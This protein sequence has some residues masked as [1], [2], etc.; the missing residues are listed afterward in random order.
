VP[1]NFQI[2]GGRGTAMAGEGASGVSAAGVIVAGVIAAGLAGSRESIN[3]LSGL[4]SWPGKSAKRVFAQMSRPS[5]SCLVCC[6]QDVDA[7][8]KAGH[9]KL[10]AWTYERS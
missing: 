8:H 4:S 9:D 5:T 10:G 6:S 1:Q 2:R 7:R 3:G